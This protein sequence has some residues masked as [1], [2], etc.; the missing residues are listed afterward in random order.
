MDKREQLIFKVFGEWA[1]ETR[2]QYVENY[3]NQ[4][5]KKHIEELTLTAK[6][7]YSQAKK[8]E[9]YGHFFGEDSAKFEKAAYEY[10]LHDLHFGDGLYRAAQERINH[11]DE[12]WRKVYQVLDGASSSRDALDSISNLSGAGYHLVNNFQTDYPIWKEI[13]DLDDIKTVFSERKRAEYEERFSEKAVFESAG[14]H[15]ARTI[16]KKMTKSKGRPPSVFSNIDTL[17]ASKFS[18]M[19]SKMNEALSEKGDKQVTIAEVCELTFGEKKKID[20]NTYG[21]DIEW[22]LREYFQ[23]ENITVRGF[24]N[25]ISRGKKGLLGHPNYNF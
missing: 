4:N 3:E 18:G 22:A 7:A 9:D 12:K 25:S 23:V 19:V 17:R 10:F 1:I 14:R 21:A 13:F 5:D 16:F 24:L 8:S 6:D 20:Q 2:R 15:Y 11:F